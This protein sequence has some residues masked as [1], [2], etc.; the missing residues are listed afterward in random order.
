M[1]WDGLSSHVRASTAID[2]ES[3]LWGLLW[4]RSGVARHVL[5]V[6]D[7]NRLGSCCCGL[8]RRCQARE[9]SPRDWTGGAAIFT[10]ASSSNCLCSRSP[11]FPRSKSSE[12]M[13]WLTL[14]RA[15]QGYEAGS[16]HSPMVRWDEMRHTID[17]GYPASV[18]VTH[19]ASLTELHTWSTGLFTSSL[20]LWEMGFVLVDHTAVEHRSAFLGRGS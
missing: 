2:K 7:R 19:I 9:S 5:G 16:N 17:R 15:P 20:P 18:R 12:R 6:G 4:N 3:V 13:P 14:W 1:R 10:P 8:P 11:V